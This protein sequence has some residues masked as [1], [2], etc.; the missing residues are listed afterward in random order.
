MGIEEEEALIIARKIAMFNSE[1]I[2]FVK[3]SLIK[4]TSSI[5]K[6]LNE[7]REKF[8]IIVRTNY[9]KTDPDL[10]IA[11]T[12]N[13]ENHDLTKLDVGLIQDMLLEGNNEP[14]D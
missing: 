7:N 3:N 2:H 4:L 6:R 13:N 5:Q 1:T 12:T 11:N 8:F 14:S 9:P 10:I